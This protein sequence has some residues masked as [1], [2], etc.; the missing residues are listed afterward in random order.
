MTRRVL[1]V[2]TSRAD[3]SHLLP[4][5][6]ALADEPGLDLAVAA[7]GMHLAQGY[8]VSLDALT[9]AGFAPDFRIPSI[10]GDSP[11]EVAAAMGR[12]IEGFSA[13]YAAQEFHMV[14]VLGDRFD[15]FPAVAAA[16]PFRLPVAHLHGGELTL[17]AIDDSI[18]HAVSKMAHVHFVAAAEFGRRLEQMGEESWRITVSGA[19]GLDAL[20]EAPF[21]DP[22]ELARRVGLPVGAPF[23]LCTLH[24][25]TLAGLDPAAQG[26][27]VA[28]VARQVPGWLVITAP[29]ADTGAGGLRRVVND[30][31][32]SRPETLMIENAGPQLYPN[33]LRHAAVVLGNS[34]S[35]IIE[36]GYFGRPVVN[37]GDR[38]AGRPTGANVLNVG[39]DCGAVAQAWRRAL[40][41][42]F[43][44]AA[45]AAE[46]PYGR[47]GAAASITTVLA[48]IP[49]DHRLMVKRFNDIVCEVP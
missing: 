43:C 48:A 17:G 14:V 7:T 19:P 4:V 29:N 5:M 25:E 8:S 44:A 42:A 2:T 45:A 21:M 9:Q 11:A 22:A 13:L 37:V 49:I 10:Q 38:Q 12:G 46:H 41:P 36:A 15:M 40:T 20:A 27:I 23:T 32:A 16:L 30:L 33:L 1:V 3:F 35:G 18:R 47:G 6:R 34:S 28:E 24:P 31:V 39:W 26:A